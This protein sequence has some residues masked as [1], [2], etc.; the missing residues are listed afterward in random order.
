MITIKISDKIRRFFYGRYGTDQLCIALVVLS[1]LFTVLS[2][3]FESLALEL[4]SSL[5]IFYAMYRMLSKKIYA[6]QKENA[7]FM[8]I[9]SPIGKKLKLWANMIRDRK[10]HRYFSCP[11]CKNTLRVPK[12][13]GEITITCPVCKKRFDKRT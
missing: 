9:W 8:K 1:M 3:I 5:L 6:R 11:G 7:A 13:K 4:L 10:T 2:G 12:G